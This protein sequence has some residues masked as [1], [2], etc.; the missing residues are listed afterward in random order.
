MGVYR[1]LLRVRE[2]RELLVMAGAGMGIGQVLG[3][4]LGVGIVAQMGSLL[5][6]GALGPASQYAQRVILFNAEYRILRD[7]GAGG[8]FY[9]F[10]SH[11][12]F[13]SAATKNAAP[14]HLFI[15]EE[16]ADANRVI[17]ANQASLTGPDA[18]GTHR[19]AAARFPRL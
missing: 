6:S 5:V 16:L 15:R 11:V 13:A 2:D 12:V 3:M 17:T 19:V 7:G 8:Q 9:Y 14:R 10:P 18:K 4:L 1:V